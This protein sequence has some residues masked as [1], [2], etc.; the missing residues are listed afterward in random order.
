MKTFL[1]LL[2]REWLQHRFGWTILALAPLVLALP[3]LTF[4]Q[5]QIDSDGPERMGVAFPAMLAMIAIVASTMVT[6]AVLW[7]TSMILITGI[8]RRDHND[9]SVEFWLSLP[10]SHVQSLGA[11]L[12]MHLIL[13]PAAALLIGLAGGTV[14]SLVLVTRLAGFGAWLSLPW[15]DVIGASLAAVLRVLAGLPLATLWLLPLT[16]ALVLFGAWFKRWGLPMLVAALAVG[17]LALKYLFGQ[18]LLFKLIGEIGNQAARALV[19]TSG[20]DRLIRDGDDMLAAL[21]LVPSWVLGD[22]GSALQALAS[23]LFLG[24]L[25]VSA[26]GFALLVDWRRRGA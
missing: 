7:I 14:V 3:L 24:G 18:P 11:P 19:P 1:T 2:Q 15:F 16:M 5:I 25:L 13:V 21:R 26:A 20:D 6:F 9:R 8:A 22:F 17:G 23:P 10:T 12:L 4:G